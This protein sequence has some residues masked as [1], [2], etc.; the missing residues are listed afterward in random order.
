M[1]KIRSEQLEAFRQQALR[2]FEDEMIKHLKEYAPKHCEALEE[3]NIR[4]VIRFGIQQA[5][6]YGLTYRGPVRFYLELIF[7]LG[8]RFDTDPQL[9]WATEILTDSA[10]TD[11]MEKADRLYDKVADYVKAVAGPKH[12]YAWRSLHNFSMAG[13]QNVPLYSSNFEEEVISRLKQIYP[14]KC[15]YVGEPALHTVVK[16][17]TMQAGTYSLNTEEGIYLFVAL[18]FALGHGFATDP[19]FPWIST[20]LNNSAISD[21]SKRIERLRSKSLTY[22]EQVLAH[23]VKE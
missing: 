11:Q 23:L 6:K 17:A 8:H 21:S 5:E 19:L 20:T 22:L 3:E 10:I 13:S 7:M 18:M 4:Y 14:E 9:G 2:Q 16:Q 1:L 12:A 15:A